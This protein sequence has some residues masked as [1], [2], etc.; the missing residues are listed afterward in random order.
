MNDFYSKIKKESDNINL[1]SFLTQRISEQIYEKEKRYLS[2]FNKRM[3][4]KI[5]L[6]KFIQDQK[7]NYKNKLIENKKDEQLIYNLNKKIDRI[8]F[9]IKELDNILIICCNILKLII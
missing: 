4:I 5:L 6:K 7:V 3:K 1:D 2:N 8:S 9:L